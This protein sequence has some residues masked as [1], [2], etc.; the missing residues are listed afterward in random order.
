MTIPSL[1][2]SLVTTPA[3][4]IAVDED[5]FIDVGAQLELHESVLH[6]HTQ[7]LDA[8][9]PIV[10]EGIGRDIIELYDRSTTVKVGQ[11]EA[12]YGD[13]REMHALR[14]QHAV[15][16]REMQGLRERVD[17]LERRMNRLES[18]SASVAEVPSASALHVLRR[19]G[20]IFTSVYAA[21]QKLKKDSWLELQFSLG[22]DIKEVDENKDKTHIKEH[23]IGKNMKAE[24]II[25]TT[26]GLSLDGFLSKWALMTRLD[27]IYSA[28]NLLY[29]GY[30]G[31]LSAALRVTRRR[32]L[33]R[34]KR[35]SDRNVFQ[36]FVFGPKEAGKSSL[37]HTL[38]GKY[39][40]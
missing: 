6:D 31:E 19:L 40:T 15:D 34:K 4:T 38:V 1:V 9:P 8:F 21:V 27:P 12:R 37:L 20:S 22:T 3:A 24:K 33:D 17:T 7:R 5:E 18:P 36:C 30:T 13:Q 26:R 14:M 16:Q 25:G 29:I 23:E 11:T 39:F 28:K 10:L 2:A 32:A 35:Q